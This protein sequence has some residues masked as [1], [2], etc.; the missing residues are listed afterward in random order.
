MV[1]AH[2]CWQASE[3]ELTVH[4]EYDVKTWVQ[5]DF[6]REHACCFDKARLLLAHTAL[7]Q[8]SQ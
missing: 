4:G 2:T 1:I 5:Q 8:G 6:K 3:D 7:I